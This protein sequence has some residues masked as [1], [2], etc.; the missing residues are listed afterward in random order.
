MKEYVIKIKATDQYLYNYKSMT[1]HVV[2]LYN[3]PVI[4]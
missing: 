3:G 4:F 2:S 1:F